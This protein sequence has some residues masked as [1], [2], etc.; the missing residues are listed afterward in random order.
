MSDFIFRIEDFHLTPDQENHIAG[1]IR[2]AVVTELAKLDLSAKPGGAKAA[3]G[4]GGFIYTPI[5]WR[6]GIMIPAALVNQAEKQTLAVT[7]AGAA[8]T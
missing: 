8:R 1:A 4:G 3:G 6:G 7:V 2:A 5:S